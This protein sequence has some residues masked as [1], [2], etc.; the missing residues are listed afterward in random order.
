MGNAF[1]DAVSAKMR[2]F[3]TTHRTDIRD[4][5]ALKAHFA[6]ELRAEDTKGEK[7][8]PPEPETDVASLLIERGID[9]ALPVPFPGFPNPVPDVID[10]RRLP[11]FQDRLGRRRD[12][13]IVPGAEWDRAMSPGSKWPLLLTP[14]ETMSV[15]DGALQIA[16]DKGTLWLRL[17]LLAPEVAID[18]DRPEYV[19]LAVQKAQA[20]LRGRGE[21]RETK[22]G[23]EIEG[24]VEEGQL[25]IQLVT[26]KDVVRTCGDITL[27]APEQIKLDWSGGQVKADLKGGWVELG[28]DRVNF[29][30]DGSTWYDAKTARFGFGAAADPAQVKLSNVTHA[31]VALR[32]APKVLAAGW[33]VAVMQFRSLRA[34]PRLRPGG[35]WFMRLKGTMGAQVDGLSEGLR[36]DE[37]TLDCTLLGWTMTADARAKN[38]TFPL[39]GW[40][41]DQG[42]QP[43][44]IAV[45]ANGPVS[46]GCEPGTG[47]FAAFTGALDA[48]LSQ[49]VDITGQ[50][51]AFH[52]TDLSIRLAERA[53]KARRISARRISSQSGPA[54]TLALE[55]A[56]I[57]VTNLS[58]SRLRGR[59]DGA[60]KLRDGDTTFVMETTAW[61]PT[62]PDP[63]VTNL[64]PQ[65]LAEKGALLEM[66]LIWT[67]GAPEIRVSGGLRARPKLEASFRDPTGTDIGPNSRPGGLTVSGR[68]LRGPKDEKAW[69]EARA[70]AAKGHPVA[71]VTA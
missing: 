71:K 68:R 66:D 23:V 2:E 56:L 14:R 36:F 20:T 61:M 63:Y 44:P 21:A 38:V 25:A 42:Q 17:D 45:A 62:Q 24:P 28:S 34:F 49:P 3:R 59:L 31:F 47:D 8:A 65:M 55:N 22:R 46:F 33:A 40:S 67:K 32:G 26:P 9:H 60:T 50:P 43:M 70:R 6:D 13:R 5:D 69:I 35:G 37:A 7:G 16:M 18:F 64:P 51:I 52:K 53:G 48:I 39:T 29:K 11:G 54:T 30:A 10:P 4:V 1:D 58:I 12:L 27:Q 19:G 41:L 15:K 57:S